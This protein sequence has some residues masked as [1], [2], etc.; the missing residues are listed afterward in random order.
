M[1]NANESRD[2]FKQ[3]QRA[4]FRKRIEGVKVFHA[5]RE[6]GIFDEDSDWLVAVYTRVSTGD[7]KQIMMLLKASA[8]CVKKV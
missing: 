7:P 3:R 1:R 6:K 2:E 5:E 8:F 4:R